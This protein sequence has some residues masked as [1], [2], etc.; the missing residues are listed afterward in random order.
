MLVLG[1]LHSDLTFAHIVKW[2]PWKSSNYLS[3]KKTY[4]DIVNNIPYV[5]YYTPMTYLF[6]NWRFVPLNPLHILLVTPSI[7]S[8]LATIF[9]PLYLWACFVSFVF[10]IMNDLQ[11]LFFYIW[12]IVLSNIL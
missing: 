8:H 10:Q 9:F 2:S 4:F 7:P 5:I 3:P 12:P 6:S 1:A 11:Y